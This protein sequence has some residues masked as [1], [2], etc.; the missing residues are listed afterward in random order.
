MSA[1]LDLGVLQIAQF[2]PAGLL[3]A[4][5]C[6]LSG[7]DNCPLPVAPSLLDPLCRNADMAPSGGQE[8][9]GVGVGWGGGDGENGSSH[10]LGQAGLPKPE[11]GS[12]QGTDWGNG[13]R[14]QLD[15]S[16]HRVTPRKG[17]AMW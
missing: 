11:A 5:V 1:P 10:G 12:C 4:P 17:L 15:L 9:A 14:V 7:P 2:P 8:E 13:P 3:L 6:L 16:T